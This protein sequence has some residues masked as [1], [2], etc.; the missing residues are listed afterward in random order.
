MSG[1][2]A[3]ARRALGAPYRMT[4]PSAFA[5][6][7]RRFLHLTATLALTDYK[8]RFFGSVLG[9]FWGLM[10]PLMLFG[11]L[12]LVF[13]KVFGVG[14]EVKDYPVQLLAGMVL[15]LFFSEATGN[16]VTSVIDR[17]N[18]VRK[19]QFP[20]LVVPAAVVLTAF[21][22]L[23]LNLV[24]VTIFVFASGVRVRWTWLELPLLLVLLLVFATG[25]AMLLS[26]LYVPFRDMKPIW[27]VVL[28]ILF[29]ATPVLYPIELLAKKNG[30]IAHIAM[31][32][33][34]A[35]IIQQLRYAVIDPGSASAGV[36]IGG[37]TRLLIPL[38]IL[39]GVF[40]LGLWVFNRMAPRI[41]EEL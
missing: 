18:L 32:N 15:Y 4:G 29:Y 22:N 38:G 36:A 27:D 17:E 5:G 13:S 21:F 34:L 11:V 7:P 16:G 12:Y 31:C 40:V 20:R 10:R 1:S 30:T 26:A 23:L 6:D 19:I 2:P 41:A 9:Y 25:F 28:Q 33:P 14:K 35:A 37:W 39:V 8:L 3:V 24:V